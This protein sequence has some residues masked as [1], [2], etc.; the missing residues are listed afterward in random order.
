MARL[1]VLRAEMVAMA[2]ALPSAES[3]Q[4]LEPHGVHRQDKRGEDACMN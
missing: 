1:A 3:L 4:R 2:A